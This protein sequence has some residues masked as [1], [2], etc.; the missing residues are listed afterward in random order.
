M[1]KLFN[2]KLILILIKLLLLLAVAKI[3]SLFIWWYFPSQSIELKEKTYYKS[4]YQK[5]DFKNML[6]NSKHKNMQ[7]SKQITVDGI[8]ITNMILKGLYGTKTKGYI[9]IAMKS[10]P[11]KTSIVAVNETYQGYTL[12]AILSK[13]VKFDKNAEEFILKLNQI[14]N[15]PSQIQEN[16]TDKQDNF[17][18][19]IVRKDIEHYSKNL[20]QIQ[21]D[22]SIK[23]DPKTKGFKVFWI[24]KN[25]KFASF[26]L[27]KNDVI[28]SAN[29]VKLNSYKDALKIY[30]DINNLNMIQ[31]V[32]IRDNKQVELVYEIN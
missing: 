29:N 13:S 6:E 1:L 3:I 7:I 21:K 11:Q 26:G 12:K 16:I 8:N 10:N 20:T 5:V 14:K 15:V 17:F 31:I 22:I 24:N 2:S 19:S 23:Q 32:V 28:I 4:K 27:K 25:S 30:E 18:K 9:I